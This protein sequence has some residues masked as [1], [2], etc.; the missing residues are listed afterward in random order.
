MI[1]AVNSF[2]LCILT[3]YGKAFEGDAQYVYV[4]AFKGGVGILANHAPML[5]AIRRGTGKVVADGETY[6]FAIGQGV[7]E[8][9]ANKV[10]V[11]VDL[12]EKVSPEDVKHLVWS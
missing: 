3:P 9:C 12:A 11:L 4:P 8:V 7:A 5:C 6:Y 10:N 1:H 2:K